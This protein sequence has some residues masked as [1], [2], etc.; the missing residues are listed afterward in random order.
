MQEQ[1][2]EQNKHYLQLHTQ[3][4]DGLTSFPWFSDSQ[5]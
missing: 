5:S 2:H 4:W 1:R 3:L